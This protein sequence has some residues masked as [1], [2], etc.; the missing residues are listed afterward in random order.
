[1]M[2]IKRDSL[3]KLTLASDKDIKLIADIE[4]ENLIKNTMEILIQLIKKHLTRK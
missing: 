1:M 2:S 4:S 3:N